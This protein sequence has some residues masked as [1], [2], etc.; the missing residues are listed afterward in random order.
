LVKLAL[1]EWEKASC[2][3]PSLERFACISELEAIQSEMENQEV[4]KSSLKKEK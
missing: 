2:I 3:P 1:K 4:T